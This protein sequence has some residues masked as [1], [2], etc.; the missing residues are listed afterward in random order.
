MTTGLEGGE[1]STSRPGRFLPPGKTGYPLYRRLAGPQGRSGQV[2]KIS[3][4]P[5]FDPRT[6]QPVANRYTDYAT[7]PTRP[8]VDTR[9]Y[10]FL[11]SVHTSFGCLSAV[12]WWWQGAFFSAVERE[13]PEAE[14]LSTSNVGVQN[15]STPEHTF[16]ARSCTVFSDSLFTFVLV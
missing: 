9:N 5:G 16:L 13:K 2:R 10:S 14:Y 4:P 7:R 6:V 8:L 15:T 1:G 3:P 12:Q 11:H